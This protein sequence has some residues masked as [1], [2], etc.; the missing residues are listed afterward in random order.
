MSDCGTSCIPCGLHSFRRNTYFNGKLLT[1]RD[2]SDEQGYLVGKDRLHN[3]LLHGHGS[4]CG[5][6]LSAHPNEDCRRRYLVLEPGLALDC[7]GREIVVA[8]RVVID[9]AALIEEQ[10]IALNPEADEDLF[11]AICYHECGDEKVPAILPDC[12]CETGNEA[13]NR[14]RESWTVSLRVERSGARP[15]ARPAARARLDWVQTLVLQQQSVTALAF[16]EERGQVYVATRAPGGGARML[17]Y[18]SHTHDLITAIETGEEVTDIAVSPRGDLIYVAGRGIEGGEGGEG[19]GGIAVYR[20][21]DIRGSD[22]A[23]PVIAL[24][25]PLRLVVSDDG[26]L[27]AL[28]LDSGDILA[29]QEPQVQAWLAGSAPAS[30]P[31]NR[32]RFDLGHAVGA[33]A[34]ARKGANVLQVSADGRQLFVLDVDAADPARRLRIVDVAAMFSGAAEGDA[35]DEITVN[36][37]LAGD[38]VALAV[39]FDRAS[40]F[41]LGHDGG[42]ARLERFNLSAP[43]GIFTVTHA[44]RGGAWEAEVLD[45][46]LAPAE[47]WAYALER[48]ADGHY[49]I[50]S[51][52]IDAITEEGDAP[53]NPAGTREGIA[54]LGSF[55]RLGVTE[56]RL[57]VAAQ[58]ASEGQPDRGLVAV[59]DVREGDCGAAFE[60][61]IG[62]CPGCDTDEHCVTLA[63]LPHYRAGAPMQDAG[64][65]G[66][67]A[68][69]IDNLTH[70]PLVPSTATIVDVV[71]CMLSQGAT[72]GRPGPRG[73]AGLAGRDGL[74]GA[75]GA[76]GAPGAD[77]QPGQTGPRGPAGPG[78]DEKL[79]HVTNLSWIH[80]D[81][82]YDRRDDFVEAL[83][84]T[85]LVILFDAEVQFASVQG[86]EKI[87]PPSE[88]FRLFARIDAFGGLLDVIVPELVLEPVE[89]TQIDDYGRI[90]EVNPTPGAALTKAVRLYLAGDGLPGVI[91]E[92]EPN[93]FRILLRADM[94][95]DAEGRFAVDGNHIFGAVP[96]RPSGNGLQGG[97]FESWFALNV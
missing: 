47:K 2:F 62:P 37:P 95:R 77:G 14:I 12:G 78:L 11:I 39:A 83:R 35:G 82:S 57:Y 54:G 86:N 60:A 23:A 44:G 80:D 40:V 43:G 41:V 84:K 75:D 91:A 97:S 27:F 24:D 22:P 81:I 71:R 92:M 10:G 31:D 68:V 18:D 25:G 55:Q 88:M 49:A 64:E 48:D 58:D 4:V 67:G 66:D 42:R 1:E 61:I 87:A 15:P 36:V 13:W 29:W 74:D 70:R 26:T 19:E 7:C 63:H 3:S 5:L 89:V 16:D 96:A 85:G 72:T 28:R 21:A 34:P 45:L 65:G 79:V 59:I 56:N 51:L 90:T 69:E 6:S 93:F 9:I 76:D 52:S 50:V 53:V 38:P 30:G 32:R 8:E 17:A 33:A 94:I 46:T 73:P 20:E